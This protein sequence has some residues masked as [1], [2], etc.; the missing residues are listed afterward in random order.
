MLATH[1][2]TWTNRF[3]SE[4]HVSVKNLRFSSGQ[5]S[6]GGPKIHRARVLKRTT[7]KAIRWT[8][9]HKR[10]WQQLAESSAMTTGIRQVGINPCFHFWPLASLVRKDFSGRCNEWL[11]KTLRK[12]PSVSE[13]MRSHFHKGIW[14]LFTRMLL[15]IWRFACPQPSCDFESHPMGPTWIAWVSL[16]GDMGFHFASLWSCI[17]G[18]FVPLYWLTL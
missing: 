13:Y 15:F 16:C 10:F 7:K 4:K 6:A 8:I 12:S 18:F 5:A 17:K 3:A 14:R 1:F 2:F 11:G 9:H